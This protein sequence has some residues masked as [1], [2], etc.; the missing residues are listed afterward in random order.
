[1]NPEEAYLQWNISLRS[2]A[3]ED[4]IRRVFE[5]VEGHCEFDISNSEAPQ[6][7]SSPVAVAP[8]ATATARAAETIRVDLERIDR[9]INLAGELVINQSMLAQRLS[10]IGSTVELPL[11]ELNHLT[12]ELQDSV[13]AIRAQPV[14]VVFQRLTRLVREVE[15]VTGKEVDFITE[16]EATEVDRTV[17]ERL[18]DPLTHMIRNAIDHGI[19]TPEERIAAG[20]PARGVVRLSAAHRGGRV[21]IE[22]K[23][24]GR[25]IN[26]ERVR[27]VAVSRGLVSADALLSEDEIDNLIFLPGFSTAQKVSELSGRGV[28]MDVVRRGVEALGGRISISSTPGTGSSFVLSLPL[29]LAILDGMLVSVSGHSLVIPLTAL[30]EA[31]QPEPGQIRP[32]GAHATLMSIRGQYVPVIDLGAALGYRAASLDSKSIVLIV[33]DDAGRRAALLVDDILGQR[34]VVIKS[35]Q[36]NYRA[37][38]GIAAAT[39]LGDGQVAL[40]VDVNSILHAHSRPAQPEQLALAG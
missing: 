28:G 21:V 15:A 39:I 19:E 18:M 1:L 7:V 38:D 13:M 27:A 16:G 2:S 32:V 8:K 26:R 12:R 6:H 22:A 3:S 17:I 4:A 40:I 11:D 9:L 37:I 5:F 31:V 24:D 23:D 10:G 20:K 36:A 14:K 25:G 34:Q 35:V 29:T 30:L 33:E